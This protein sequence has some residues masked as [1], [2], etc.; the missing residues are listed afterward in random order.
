MSTIHIQMRPREW[1]LLLLL[2][3]I[4]GGSFLFNG[5]ALKEL[6]PL[7][8]VAVRVGLAAIAL[9]VVMRAQGLVLP[10]NP[11]LWL[12]FFWLGLFNNALPFGLIVWAQTHIPSGLASILNATVPLFGV[13]V[14]HFMTQDEKVDARRVLGVLTG[15]AGVATMVGDGM[16]G[17][18]QDHIYGELAV[19]CAALSYAFATVYG[20][21]FKAWNI[22]PLTVTT[23][24][25]TMASLVLMPLALLIDAP[26]TLTQPSVSTWFSLIM[27][28][29]VSTALA[30]ILYFKILSS[31]GA[32]NVSLVTLLIPPFA[33]LLGVF[34]LGEQL[35]QRHFLGMTLIAIG[36]LVIDGRLLRRLQRSAS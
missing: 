26:W 35:E 36:F 25:T 2:A 7:V 3:L 17:L 11:H 18:P 4:W 33:I 9:H 15:V 31:A 29:L 14:A 23:G 12:G 30:Y 10:R 20:R 22:A 5:L 34:V 28:A 24:Q 16:S 13:V 6:P 8:I 32:V 21:R 27:L 1:A 19:L